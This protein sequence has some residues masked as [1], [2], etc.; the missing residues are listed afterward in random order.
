MS[1][2]VVNQVDPRRWFVLATVCL[3]LFAIPMDMTI[4][5]TGLPMLSMALGATEPEKIWIVSIYSLVMAGLLPLCG[6]LADRYGSR[7]LLLAGMGVFALSSLGASLSQTPEA[8][9]IA[10]ALMGVGGAMV[11]PASVAIVALTFT[12]P[13]ERT[14]ALSIWNSVA[15]AGAAVGPFVGGLLL[16]HFWWGAIFLVNVPIFLLLTPAALMLRDSAHRHTGKIDL[17]G[18]ALVMAGLIALIWTLE[19]LTAGH[20]PKYMLVISAL[21]AVGGLAAFTRRQLRSDAPLLDMRSLLDR[22]MGGGVFAA[23]L[24]NILLFGTLLVLSQYLQLVQG[25]SPLEAGLRTIP[26]FIGGFIIGPF[27]SKLLHHIGVGS[28]LALAFATYALFTA[29]L[30]A[31]LPFSAENPVFLATTLFLIG[32]GL[33]TGALGATIAIMHAPMDGRTAMTGSMQEVSFEL[34]SAIGATLLGG[35]LAAGYVLMLEAPANVPEQARQSIGFA[36]EWLR[37]QGG[38]PVLDQLFRASFAGSF[39]NCLIVAATIGFAASVIVWTILRP[40]DD[41]RTEPE[42]QPCE[43]CR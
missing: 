12:D 2:A 35:L 27:A 19:N 39:R 15:A 3:A 17:P 41:R 37:L 18:A 24:S 9:I 13:R 29:A 1:T 23:L 30:A 10:R 38:D 21:I 7:T 25:L 43:D 8:L 11:M 4:L 16:E 5:Y 6:N 34:G 40:V 33:G 31:F 28:L 36:L 20:A 26:I 22:R 32:C 14:L 42:L